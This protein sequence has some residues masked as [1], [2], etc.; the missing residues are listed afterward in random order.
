MTR[1]ASG[2]PAQA[3]IRLLLAGKFAD[4]HRQL[5]SLFGHRVACVIIL[6]SILRKPEETDEDAFEEPGRG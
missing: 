4:I 3:T 2:W 1:P 6:R 5:E